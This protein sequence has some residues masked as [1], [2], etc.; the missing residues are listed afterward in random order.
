M[1]AVPPGLSAVPLLQGPGIQGLS[2]ALWS[3]QAPTPRNSQESLLKQAGPSW[4][5]A[6]PR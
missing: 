5:G 6:M 2:E 4:A 1:R 3:Q